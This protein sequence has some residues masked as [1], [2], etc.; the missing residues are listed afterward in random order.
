MLVFLS[1]EMQS[2][3]FMM[4]LREGRE[5]VAVK[6]LRRDTTVTPLLFAFLYRC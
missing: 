2:K 4:S 5:L 1:R 6:V 3:Q